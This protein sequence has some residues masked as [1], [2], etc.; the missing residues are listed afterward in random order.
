VEF[1]LGEIENLPIADN[2]G[3]IIISNC[4]I[5]LSPNKQRVFQEAHRV[6]KP[7]GRLIISEIV[8]LGEIAERVKNNVLAYVE[9]IAGAENKEDYLK[10]IK[11]A[12]LHQIEVAKEEHLPEMMFDESDIQNTIGKLKLTKQETTD[13]AQRI[14]RIKV[15]VVKP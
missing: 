13:I 3:D 6:L 14:V 15:S 1:R 7:K 11:Q 5:N 9:Y 8:L 2:T 12:G 4:V 10:M